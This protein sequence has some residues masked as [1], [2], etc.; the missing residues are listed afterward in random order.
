[1]SRWQNLPA[2]E[3]EQIHMAATTTTTVSTTVVNIRQHIGGLIRQEVADQ[4][5]FLCYYRNVADDRPI[6]YLCELG[7]CPNGCCSAGELAQ[8]SSS[9]GW[10]IA[11]LVVFL[12]VILFVIVAMLSIYLVNKHK[13]RKQRENI[14]E[15][16][17]QS[18]VGSQI[19]GPTYYGQEAYYPYVPN[20]APA[21]SY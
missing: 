17:A 8:N 14:A 3:Q 13:D 1:M 20:A 7:C 5:Q 2:S 4:N 21:T 18:S 6:P 9:Y 11:L 15:S 19:S 10:A 12:L 16:S